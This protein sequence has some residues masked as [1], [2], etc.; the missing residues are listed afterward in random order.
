MAM[1]HAIIRLAPLGV[2]FLVAATTAMQGAAVFVTL[3]G[4]M[5]AVLV[6]L[7]LL[8][9]AQ[10]HFGHDLPLAQQVVVCVTALP[11]SVGAA[12]IPHAGLVVMAIILQ[13][14]EL[15]AVSRGIILAVD[16]VL[17]MVRTRVNVWSDARGAAVVD[18]WEG[19][20]TPP[21]TGGA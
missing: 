3:S 19:P 1:T 14:V 13:A 5:L 10:L 16:R 21:A 2:L 7:A 15:P 4:H 12:G 6:A 17:D 8:F 20:D 18:A 9:I 11:A